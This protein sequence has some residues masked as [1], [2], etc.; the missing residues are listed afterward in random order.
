[1]LKVIDASK[2]FKVAIEYF[3]ALKKVNLT[4]EPGCIYGVIGLSGAG[5]STLLR[6]LAGLEEL[7]SGKIIIDGV[8]ISSLKGK[9]KREFKKKIGVVF[10][11]Y[12][13]LMQKTVYNNIAFPLKIAKW[14]KED[15]DKRV[16][17]LI[18]IVGLEGKENSYPAK[19]SGG[20]KQRVAIAR[21]IALNPKILLLDELTSALDPLTTESIL[22]L[23]NDINQKYHTTMV[24]ITHEMNVIRRVCS[25]VSVINY[26]EIV[27]T[28]DA[29]KV[30]DNPQS[31]IAKMIMGRE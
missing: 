29:S 14:N 22:D 30:L 5:K 18:K 10:Q 21:G 2:N 31:D 8:D 28:N 15:I 23:L 11:G 25:K 24:L 13:L 12:N 1:M 7:D 9:T 20:Q 16:K 19:L 4:V 27:E 26:G 3:H 6:C 17:E